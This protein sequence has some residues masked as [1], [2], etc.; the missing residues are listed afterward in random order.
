MACTLSV[1][2]AYAELKLAYASRTGEPSWMKDLASLIQLDDEFTM[3]DLPDFR[4]V[5]PVGM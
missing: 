4:E 5:Y 1:N 3:W 2:A